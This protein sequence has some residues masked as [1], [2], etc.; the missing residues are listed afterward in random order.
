MTSDEWLFSYEVKV[1]EGLKDGDQ[2]L[3]DSPKTLWQANKLDTGKHDAKKEGNFSV[4]HITETGIEKIDQM[5]GAACKM[6]T[7]MDNGV[8][9]HFILDVTHTLTIGEGE[10]TTYT[11]K[12]YAEDEETVISTKDTYEVGQKAEFPES[13]ENQI[14]WA[15]VREGSSA[16][17]T[18]LYPAEDGTYDYT[19]K[20]ADVDFLRILSTKK[21]P[22]KISLGAQLFGSEYDVKVDE[23]KLEGTGIEF[24]K[25]EMAFRIMLPIGGS[26]DLASI[27][28]GAVV[29]D[30]N[31]ITG[32]DTTTVAAP[33]TLEGTVLTLNAVNGA[34]GT[35]ITV[36]SKAIWATAEYT[37]NFYLNKEAVEG[38]PLKTLTGV[39]YNDT[40]GFGKYTDETGKTYTIDGL[41]T[42]KKFAGWYNAAN[43]ELIASADNIRYTYS[44]DLNLYAYWSDYKNSATFMVRDYENGKWVEY[45]YFPDRAEGESAKISE[46]DVEKTIAGACAD[47]SISFKNLY[48]T[49]PD[50][51][52]DGNYKDYQ[53]AGILQLAPGVYGTSEITYSGNQVYYIATT[54]SYEVTWKAPAYDEATNS[55]DE[56]KATV[57]STDKVTTAV[58][59]G[60]GD[61][62]AAVSKPQNA[63]APVGYELASWKNAATGEAVELNA[64]GAYAVSDENVTLIATYALVNYPIA[65]NLRNSATSDIVMLDGTVTLGG[66]IEIKDAK[67]TLKGEASALPEIGLEND[68][69]PAGGY[70]LPDGYKFAGWTFGIDANA[71][72]ITF[73]VKLT[74]DIIRKNFANGAIQINASW[75]AQEYTL[76]FY[77]LNA[78]GNEEL[79]NTYKVKAGADLS[80]YKTT[81]AEVV[82][83]INAK[84]PAGKTFS[85]IWINKE[86][87]TTDTMTKMPA[88]DVNYVAS[89]GTSTISVYVDYDFLADKDLNQTMQL[90]KAVPLLYGAD[91]A[92][93]KEE[94]PYYNRSY[95]T[96]VKRTIIP[97]TS[98]PASPSE[99]IGWNIYHVAP[100]AD[101]FTAE[102][103]PGYND[104]GTTIATTTIIFQPIWLAHKDMLFRVYDTD[105]NLA[106]ALGKNLKTY[107]W[108]AGAIVDS[109]KDTAI[110]RNTDLYIAYILTMSIENWNWSEFFNIEMWQ[111]LTLRFDPFPIPRSWL[112]WEGFKGLLEAIGNALGSLL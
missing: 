99:V 5:T 31:E 10:A 80:A 83:A 112:T 2:G 38:E 65:F 67:F 97:E 95:E 96:V 46:S 16:P 33:S 73:P 64:N 29:K 100:G 85:Q 54:K 19:M 59:A 84:A 87:N 90:F 53:V 50:K 81:S 41:V 14:G 1:K 56:S 78:E 93:V 101:P 32:W 57:I 75:E 48:T 47:E 108:N 58:Y 8:L 49:D 13:V 76:T 23:T 98:K 15:I 88:K 102:W 3:I 111:S 34:M 71:E 94:E 30:G 109:A 86:T 104:E 24:L 37:V 77:I 36:S 44:D 51:I 17:G 63:A 70:T 61:P 45:D 22:V 66:S 25:D 68:K 60:N 27:P 4:R 21:Y 6:S 18:I 92:V 39:K 43:D 26:F 79:F 91:V 42:D 40:V 72:A 82:A 12:F 103:K 11:A 9:D 20:E 7:Q 89:Y 74:A 55:F 107:F 28:E 106:H 69:Q 35:D 62:Y 105:G 110:N 52:T